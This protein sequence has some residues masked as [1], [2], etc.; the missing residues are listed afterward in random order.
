[1]TVIVPLYS[2]FKG[3]WMWA[4]SMSI[5]AIGNIPWKEDRQVYQYTSY[6]GN[7]SPVCIV[8]I[9]DYFH[10]ID[11]RGTVKKKTETGCEFRYSECQWILI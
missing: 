6:T 4:Q 10:S 7:C 1:M 3:T 11:T 2:W 5:K 9:Y 8:C